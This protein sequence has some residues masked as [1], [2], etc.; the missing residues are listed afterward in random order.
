MVITAIHAACGEED[1]GRVQKG[2]LVSLKADIWIDP[3]VGQN[4]AQAAR[5]LITLPE[6][7]RGR[8][9]GLRR[10]FSSVPSPGDRPYSYHVSGRCVIPPISIVA[11]ESVE[12]GKPVESSPA[13]DK[14]GRSAQDDRVLV[15]GL[16]S[17][18]CAAFASIYDC[19]APDVFALCL[20][21]TNDHA[22]ADDLLLDVFTG[23]W[24]QRRHLHVS[25][26]LRKMLL[27]STLLCRK[28]RET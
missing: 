5:F 19:Y 7:H 28:V 8:R 22:M 25:V 3:P 4:H 14:S 26:D 23:L 20:H 21:L 1:W 13:G 6:L 27:G 15:E 11:L 16:R 18:D 12:P 24:K 10:P 9:P 17:D 2:L